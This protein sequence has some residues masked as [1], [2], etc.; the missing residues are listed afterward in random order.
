MLSRSLIDCKLLFLNI[1]IQVSQFV[2][3]SHNLIISDWGSQL[4]VSES[5]SQ[6]LTSQCLEVSREGFKSISCCDNDLGF[7]CLLHQPYEFSIRDC[8]CKAFLIRKKGLLRIAV[9]KQMMLCQWYYVEDKNQSMSRF[10]P[11]STDNFFLS[12]R[13]MVSRKPA[14]S[15]TAVFVKIVQNN[16]N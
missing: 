16:I 12:W 1:M 11:K 7:F 15:K 3:N 8:R 5:L 13:H 14:R 10:S 9:T 2:S 6:T 4:V